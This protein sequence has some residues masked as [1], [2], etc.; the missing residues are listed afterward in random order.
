M[1]DSP[2]LSICIPTFNRADLLESCLNHLMEVRRLH[3]DL[4]EVVVI[5]NLSSDRTSKVMHRWEGTHNFRSVRRPVRISGNA[6]VVTSPR[7]FASGEYF[8]V[9]G[10]DD[11]VLPGSLP[12]LI[13]LIQ[14]NQDIDYFVLNY[15]HG[16][17]EDCCRLRMENLPDYTPPTHSLACPDQR[18]IRQ[19]SLARIL[20]STEGNF[21]FPS[22]VVGQVTRTR[23][24]RETRLSNEPLQQAAPFRTLEDTFPHLVLL[25][26][27]AAGRPVF[28]CGRPL[29]FA[30]LGAQE[31]ARPWW[32]EFFYRCHELRNQWRKLGVAPRHLRLMHQRWIVQWTGDLHRFWFAEPGPGIRPS[33]LAKF[34]WR[35]LPEP[36]TLARRFL[37]LAARKIKHTISGS[38]IPGRPGDQPALAP[39]SKQT[40]S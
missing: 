22:H 17:Y 11:M 27:G 35:S 29:A 26:E 39:K 10:D 1:P 20:E 40:H 12:F 32:F 37:P 21:Q 28:Y 5:D 24:W 25:F 30:S 31:W 4:I 18:I 19:D 38:T 3:T 13:N 9:M 33:L 36:A 23:R 34:I 2:L 6:N 15:C 16:S 8:W 14:Q 7:E